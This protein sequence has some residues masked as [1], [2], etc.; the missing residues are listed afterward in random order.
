MTSSVSSRCRSAWTFSI[1]KGGSKGATYAPA[2]YNASEPGFQYPQRRIEGCNLGGG[3][4]VVSPVLLS[5]SPKADRRVQPNH[6]RLL[7]LHSLPPFSIPKGGSKGATAAGTGIP[8]TRQKAFSIPKGGSKGATKPDYLRNVLVTDFQ[9]P[10]RRIE[11]CNAVRVDGVGVRG[12]DF[13]YPQRR[14][15]G[16]NLPQAF[17]VVR[18]VSPFSIP[19]GGSKGATFILGGLMQPRPE[20]FS[21][22][23]G[24]S[25]GAT[26]VG[27]ADAHGAGGGFQY[28]QRRI[29]GCN[30][31]TTERESAGNRL[32]VS[33]KADRR[34][35]PAPWQQALFA[36]INFQYPQRRIEGCNRMSARL[37]ASASRL[38][39]SPKADRRVQHVRHHRQGGGT[40]H[41]SV[42]P[43]ADRRVQHCGGCGGGGAG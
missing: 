27:G 7:H 43:K 18:F 5:V 34:V 39:V 37:C 11:G 36:A 3:C 32:S 25:K 26:G 4:R 9:Y 15:E 42:S 41:L 24:G 23:K 21:I 1:P 20:P 28:P 38:S 40:G 17:R 30:S 12:V 13:Q 35:Q 22:P 8:T 19:K 14:I 10:Q 33:P 6:R 31:S 29:E 16:C 2:R